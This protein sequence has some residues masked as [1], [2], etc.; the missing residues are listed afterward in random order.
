MP[1]KIELEKDYYLHEFEGEVK[2]FFLNFPLSGPCDDYLADKI[3]L[4]KLANKAKAKSHLRIYGAWEEKE[5]ENDTDNLGRILWL[6]ALAMHEDVDAED[7]TELGHVFL[8]VM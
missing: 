6:M 3:H 7:G 4:F 8:T 5:L 2:D 1:F